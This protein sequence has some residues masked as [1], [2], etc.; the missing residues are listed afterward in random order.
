MIAAVVTGVLSSLITAIIIIC[1]NRYYLN[2]GRL[3]ISCKI[4]DRGAF[5]VI[6]LQFLWNVTNTGR[7][8]VS[9]ASV[10]YAYDKGDSRL[11]LSYELNGI[12]TLPKKLDPTEGLKGITPVP[13]QVF[14]SSF[15]LWAMDTMGNKYFVNQ[16]NVQELVTFLK[17]KEPERI[18]VDTA[19]KRNMRL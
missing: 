14:D 1:L 8:T 12:M 16:I 13:D 15:K 3:S 7:G 17:E 6:P 2:K 11:N 4:S 5:P 9:L 19:I 10:G 18:R